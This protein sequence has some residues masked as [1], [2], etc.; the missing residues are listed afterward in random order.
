MTTHLVAIAKLVTLLGSVLFASTAT[1]QITL[2]GSTSFQPTSAFDMGTFDASGSDKL[3]VVATG[4]HNFPNNT[5]GNITNITYDGVSLFRVVDRNPL[6]GTDQTANDIWYLDNPGSVH[7]GGVLDATVVGNGNNYV[8]TV[9]GLSGTA[10]GVGATAISAPGS[11]SVD[12]VAQGD[13]SFVLAALGMGGDGNTANVLAVDAVLPA[14]ELSALE[15]GNNWAGHVTS[16]TNGVGP[17]LGTYSFTGGST[18]GVHT[19]A[20]E[21]LAAAAPVPEPGAVAIWSLLGVGLAVYG[22]YSMRRKRITS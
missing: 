3:V 6:S 5:T 2:N 1:A 17:G 19:I 7:V 20:A 22:C 15:A 18:T 11:K 21:F 14:I 13:D 16:W 9:L 8:F 10:P 12:L 4:E